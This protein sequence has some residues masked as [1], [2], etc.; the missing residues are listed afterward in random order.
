M[1]TSLNPESCSPLSLPPR[2]TPPPPVGK[3]LDF[4]WCR[5][6]TRGQPDWSL[7]GEGILWLL[8]FAGEATLTWKD[9]SHRKVRPGSMC[10]L[11]PAAGKGLASAARLPGSGHDCLVLYFSDAW[12]EENLRTLRLDLPS[13]FRV[14][15]LGPAPLIPV[16]SRPLEP[17]DKAWAQGLLAP[18]LCEAAR[19]LLT[20][21]RMTDFLLQKV[22]TPPPAGRELFCTRTKWLAM[23]RV[24]K[25]KA[26]LMEALDEPPPLEALATLAGV[27]PHHLSR[28]FTQVEGITLTAW[29]R[30]QRIGRAAHLIAT[31]RCNV[32]EAAVEVGY[33]SLSHFSR[34]FLEEKGVPP[35]RWTQ[36][37][38]KG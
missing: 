26:A 29:L 9:G 3:L 18:H 30:R 21:A 35:S 1:R 10:C 11:R 4:I 7:P 5:V 20:K 13:D 33:Q 36:H 28:T 15:L 38:Q 34:A 37:A 14:V 6:D 19:A 8:N 23:E 27:N 12:L 24:E 17:A 22:F 25:V 31:G 16:V 32:S 2:S